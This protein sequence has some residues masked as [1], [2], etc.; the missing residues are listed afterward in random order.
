MLATSISK[1]SLLLGGFALLTA[2]TLAT[3]N[4]LTQAPIAQAEQAAAQKALLEILPA[5]THDNHMLDDTLAIPADWQAQLHTD[6]NAKIFRARQGETVVAVIIPT[7]APDGYSGKIKM[8][9]GVNSDKTLAGVRVLTHTETPGLGDKI[10]LKKS[11][12]ML[13]FNGLK[14]TRDN[15]S[16]WAVKKD[17]GAFDQFTGATITPR[18]VIKQVKNTL[19]FVEHNHQSLFHPSTHASTETQP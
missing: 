4:L 18:A 13:S 15:Q 8:I 14:L 2:S 12:W 19:Q 11:T 10:E 6:A 3:V 1:N 9:V 7:T 5:H 17:G 16:Q